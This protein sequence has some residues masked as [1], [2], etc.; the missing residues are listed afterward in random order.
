ML[1]KNHFDDC[2]YNCNA[3]GMVLDTTIKKLVPCPHCSKLKKE[4]L[5]QGYVETEQDERVPLATVL[6]I[7]NEFLS[8]KFVYEGIVPDGE[9]LF[10]EEE[11]VEWQSEIAENM[12]LDLSIGILPTESL[13]FGISI[14]GKIEQFAYPMLAKAYLGGL[15]I[16]KFITCSEFNRLSF[17]IENSME[18]FY[19][20]DF[21]LMLINDGANLADISSAKGLMQTRALKGKPTV[22]LTTWTIEACSALL[23]FADNNSLSLAKPVFLKYKTSKSKGHSSYINKLLGVENEQVVKEDFNESSSAS[24]VSMSDLLKM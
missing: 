7:N 1:A 2:P 13:C 17:N 16:G 5:K 19:N 8:S 11:S 23:G 3:K 12:Y 4:L 10:I 15:T 20:S 22:F 9:L 14:K 6:G 18:D 24:S 21:L